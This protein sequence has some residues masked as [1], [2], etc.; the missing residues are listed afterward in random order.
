MGYLSLFS[1]HSGQG[2]AQVMLVQ[3]WDLRF[4]VGAVTAVV[5]HVVG[6]GQSLGAAGLAGQDAFDLCARQAVARHDPADLQLYRA[7]HDQNACAVRL[8]S[9]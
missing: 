7:I 5:D 2:C 3:G 9:R 1:R 4:Q 6:N 8:P